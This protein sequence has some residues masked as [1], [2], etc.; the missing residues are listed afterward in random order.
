[1]RRR[2][3]GASESLAV[4]V[5]AAVARMRDGRRAEAARDRRG[6]RLARRAR[7]ARRRRRSTRPRST[8]R[9]ARCSS[10]ARTRTWSA[11]PAWSSSSG[12]AGE[13]RDRRARPA[14]ARRRA[15]AAA[16]TTAGVPVTPERSARFAQALTLVRP[17]ARRRLYWTARATLVSDPAQ[18]RAFDAVFAEVFGSRVIEPEAGAGGR[19]PPHARAAR[20]AAGGEPVR[21]RRRAARAA[22]RPRRSRPAS[23]V[24]RPASVPV[25]VAASDEERLRGKRFDAL[26]P[27]ELARALPADDAAADRDADAPHAPRRARPPRRA[28]RPAAHAARQPAHRR[29]PDPARAPAPPRRPPPARAA[30]RHLGL[31]GALRARL[32]AVPHVRD[33]RGRT[34]RRSCS[35]RG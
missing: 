35:P 18:V 7:A 6:D 10:T 30:V 29:R 2:V 16:C 33:E 3:K 25:P 5:V 15:S 4:Q 22:P 34:P 9:S 19:A 1:M 12:A 13:G 26:E 8:A 31:D 17:V 20:R 21:R 28:H 27:G 14:G 32:P 24:R 11:P 23:A